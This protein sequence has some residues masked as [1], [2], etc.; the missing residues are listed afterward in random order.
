MR[1]VEDLAKR[2]QVR[3]MQCKYA[4]MSPAPMIRHT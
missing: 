2:R 1:A 3:M 4:M